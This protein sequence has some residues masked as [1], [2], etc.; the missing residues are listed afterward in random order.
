MKAG[1][2]R[3]VV[4]G[5][6]AISRA[7]HVPAVLASPLAKL[8]GVVDPDVARAKSLC[9]S[10]G[11]DAAVAADIQGLDIAYDAAIIAVPNDLHAPVAASLIRKKIHVLIEKPI[12]TSAAA[13]LDL[14]KLAQ[15]SNVVVAVGYHTRHSGACQ[16]L[17]YAIDSEHFGPVIRFAHQDGSRGGWSPMSG[18]NLDTKRAGGG[19]LVT[20]GTHMLDRLV[21]FWGTPD[22]VSL[23]DNSIGGPESHCIARFEFIVRG[24]T[25][26]GA[27]IFSKVVSLP[28]RT[29]VQT[30]EGL[31]VMSSDAA[32]TILFRPARDPRLEYQVSLPERI[33]DSRSLYQRELDDFVAA[34]QSGG[35]PAVDAMAGVESLK[36]LDRLYAARKPLGA[37]SDLSMKEATHV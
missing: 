8:A 15:E 13:A 7:A 34:C 27:A 26:P 2:F 9:Q 31:L 16:A 37:G 33:G 12:A 5:A 3:V 24:R 18:Y 11:V 6:G 32:E 28:E 1:R 30:S 10:Y 29:V 19:V 20:T 14:C 36:L 22:R 4:V 17:K 21:W 23:R 35:Q 25:I